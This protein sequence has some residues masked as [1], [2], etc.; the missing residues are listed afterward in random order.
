MVLAINLMEAA[1]ETLGSGVPLEIILFVAGAAGTIFGGG[2]AVGILKKR[3]EDVE[4]KMSR[5]KARV[6]EIEAANATLLGALGKIVVFMR[7]GD[8]VPKEVLDDISDVLEA[9][10]R[11]SHQQ[12]I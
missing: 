3:F 6:E 2:V 5:L 4:A 9:P 10:K 7:H 12:S 11:R 1:A 8:G